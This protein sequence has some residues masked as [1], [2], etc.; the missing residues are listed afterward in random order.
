VTA[1]PLSVWNGEIT[2]KEP[3]L[4]L[5]DSEAK[6]IESFMIHPRPGLIPGYMSE[7]WWTLVK[8]TVRK[9]KG[10]GM[11]VW[12][13]DEISYPSG[14]A[15]GHVPAQMP[16]S[17]NQ[18]QGLVAKQFA[19]DP[20]AGTNCE[21][22]LKREGTAYC[23]G[24]TFEPKR[25]WHEG[26]SY[27]DLLMPGGTEKSI[28]LTMRRGYEKAIGEEFGRR[29]PGIFTD[30]PHIRPPGPNGAI[31]WTPDL[32][33]QFRK[34]KGYDLKESLASLVD[35]VGDWQR[36]RGDYYAVLLGLFVER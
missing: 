31:R 22:L 20:P 18:G 34:R 17:H 28:E 30:E 10:L 5:E 36:V 27:V 16:E 3:D 15:G 8:H 7:R 24:K 32:F 21:V 26:D 6:G 2:E 13:Y 23:F 19:G 14:F 35:T 1:A 9:A 25:A 4:F 11:I 29:V 12:L 33:E